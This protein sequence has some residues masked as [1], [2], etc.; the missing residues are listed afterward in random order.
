[1]PFQF[2]LDSLPRIGRL[3][4]TESVEITELE[5]TLGGLLSDPAFDCATPLLIDLRNLSE[6][7][8]TGVRDVAEHLARSPRKLSGGLALL[9]PGLGHR[10]TGLTLA[11]YLTYEGTA[12]R[13]F[14]EEEVALSW[15]AHTQHSSPA[16]AMGA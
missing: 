12:T 13:V 2:L 11:M 9:A 10:I 1:V 4:S 15:L 7:S 16:T 5:R 6:C 8:I 3:V 14:E